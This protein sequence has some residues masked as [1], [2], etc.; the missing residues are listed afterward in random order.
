[1]VGKPDAVELL[2]RRAVAQLGLVAERE[3]GLVAAGLAARAAIAS[4]SSGVM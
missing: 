3:E 2:A 4:T 1:M